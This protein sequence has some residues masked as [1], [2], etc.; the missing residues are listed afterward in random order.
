VVRT[1]V[2]WR[3]AGYA[4]YRWRLRSRVRRSRLPRHVA[5]IMDG[6][7]RW[8]TQQG[9]SN[10]SLGHR[11]GAEHVE[12]LLDWCRSL[13]IAHVTVFVC[14]T[15]NLLRRGD[16][17][18]AA[19]MQVIEDV[20]TERLSQPEPAWQVHVA[21]LL[22]VLPDSTARALKAAVEATRG[23]R[24][25][26]H[27]TLAVGYGGRQEVVEAVRDVLVERAAA[28]DD[29]PGLAE[30]LTSSEIERE[31]AAHLSTVGQPD[32]DLVIRTSGEIRM[33]NFLLWQSVRS[34][35]FFC[36]AN[37]PAFRE[38]DFLRALR[39]NAQRARSG[40]GRSG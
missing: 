25:G 34:E 15:E 5:V 28:G 7:R 24:T 22:D 17:E 27:V 30:T 39:G 21:G 11:H 29:L 36:D 3:S 32:P 19:L 9:M 37:W 16:A 38:I 12:D 2:S 26:A 14:S 13:G 40:M 10:P 1:R 8:A 4:V 23:C 18:V 35:L 33:S 6:N 31:I 20:V